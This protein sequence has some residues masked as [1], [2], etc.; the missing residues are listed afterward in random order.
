MCSGKESPGRPP[1]CSGYHFVL[2]FYLSPSSSLSSHSP[3]PHPHQWFPI[4][5]PL[6]L[7]Y[8]NLIPCF[9]APL[10]IRCWESTRKLSLSLLPQLIFCPCV[11]LD[12]SLCVLVRVSCH[13]H[14]SFSSDTPSNPQH[15]S[16]VL[17]HF[18]PNIDLPSTTSP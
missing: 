13:H 7:C 9:V 12:A 1:S 18:S 3:Y 14:S 17:H 6:L 11:S 15:V 2:L 4:F 10:S 8:R 16:S 5:H